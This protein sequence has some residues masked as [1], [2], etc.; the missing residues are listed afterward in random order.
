MVHV[1]ETEHGLVSIGQNAK[2]N[3]ELVSRAGQRDTWFHVKSTSSAHVLLH[4]SDDEDRPSRAAI[5]MCASLAK[6]HSKMR[7]V[8]RC[9]VMFAPAKNV[10]R[11]DAVGSVTVTKSAEVMI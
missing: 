6:E 5:M 10:R 3:W 4:A 1:M 9:K 8:R 2:E 11:A 7:H